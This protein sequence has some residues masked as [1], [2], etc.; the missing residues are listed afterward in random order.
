MDSVI[1][2]QCL[3]TAWTAGG[4]YIPLGSAAVGLAA[5]AAAAADNLTADVK[6]YHPA[7]L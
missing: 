6:K 7:L 2:R 5:A 1:F 4:H 3:P